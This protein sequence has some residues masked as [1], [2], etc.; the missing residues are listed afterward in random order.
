MEAYMKAQDQLRRDWTVALRRRPVRMV[1]GQPEGGWTD[2]YEIVCCD[3]GD[4][5]DRDWR[6]VSPALQRVRGPY[7]I[8]AGITAYVEHAARHPDPPGSRP[9]RERAE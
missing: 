6:E 7:P 5:P 2:E 4:D 3:C 1:A 9:P 8:A